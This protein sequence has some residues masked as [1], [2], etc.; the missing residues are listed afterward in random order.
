MNEPMNGVDERIRAALHAAVDDLHER[1]LRPALPPR[2]VPRRHRTIRWAA[3]LLAAAA[4]VAVVVTSVAVSSGPQAA[5][6]TIAPAGSLPAPKKTPSVS[7]TTYPPSAAKSPE[8]TP[9]G[10]P[11][12]KT[13]PPEASL[14]GYEPLWPF[15]SLTQA[16]AWEAANLRGGHSSWHLDAGQTALSFVRSYLKF[17]DITDVTSTNVT[18]KDAHIG[19]GYPSPSGQP[20]TAAVLHLLRFA[21]D[22]TDANAP[23]E[24]VEAAASDFSFEGTTVT[25][26][27]SPWLVVQGRI[28]G[29]D[30]NITVAARTLGGAVRT[31]APVPAGGNNSRWDVQMAPFGL[32]GVVTVV[33]STGGHTTAHERFVVTGISVP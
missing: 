24:V 11:T 29:A 3:P 15:D 32:R 5:K 9:T 20:H 21:A 10:Q 14:G 1:D 22:G 31:A 2:G 6:H 18:T 19:V 23:W 30:E 28:S 7:I 16:E 26:P 4:V 17:T 33:A 12:T 25:D 27:P 13:P 8:T